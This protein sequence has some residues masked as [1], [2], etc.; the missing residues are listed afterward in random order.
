LRIICLLILKSSNTWIVFFV[1]YSFY[2]LNRIGDKHYPCPTPLS[3]S[4]PLV[5][6]SSSRTETNWSI[7]YLLMRFLSRQSIPVFIRIKTV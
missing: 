3:V 1:R 5:S 2:K 7:C 4:T 6:P